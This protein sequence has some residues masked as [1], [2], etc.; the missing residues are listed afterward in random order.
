MDNMREYLISIIAVSIF[1][2]VFTDL[3]QTSP[4][5]NAVKLVSGILVTLTILSPLLHIDLRIPEIESN[6]IR[7]KTE[8]VLEDATAKSSAALREV[9]KQ[10]TEE[11]ILEKATDM[12]LNVSVSVELTGGNPPLPE[13]VTIHGLVQPYFRQRLESIL[14]TQLGIEKEQLEWTGQSS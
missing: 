2:S 9:I 12:D 3:L 10:K 5:R 6:L 14:C 1:C 8:D 7:G 4:I 13:R 11:Y